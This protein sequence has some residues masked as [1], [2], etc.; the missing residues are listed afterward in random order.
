MSEEREFLKRFADSKWNYDDWC[1][2]KAVA[3]ELLAQP[4]QES[5]THEP[6]RD[7]EI[8]VGMGD[9]PP[10]SCNGFVRGVKFAEKAH[11][12]GGDDS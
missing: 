11:G 1:F 8:W 4:E 12:I 3:K 7:D 5:P 2:L 10:I 9:E 6:L